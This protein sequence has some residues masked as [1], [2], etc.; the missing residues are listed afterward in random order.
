MNKKKA[1]HGGVCGAQ[2]LS[3]SQSLDLVADCEEIGSPLA[4]ET[5]LLITS[6]TNRNRE[7]AEFNIKV[8]EL[9]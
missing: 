2:S 6:T 7:S 9:A 1:P 3:A 5:V 4:C 8:L